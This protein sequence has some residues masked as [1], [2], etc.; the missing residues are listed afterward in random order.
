MKNTILKIFGTSTKTIPD[1]T[2]NQ[3]LNHF[4]DAINIEWEIKDGNYEAVFY[5]NDKEYIAKISKENEITGYKRNLKIEEL[6]ETIKTE[7]EK[8][9][10]IMNAIAIHT[11]SNLLFEI[12]VRD[13]EFKRSL[14]LLSKSGELLQLSAI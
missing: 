7:C 14:L 5:V 12:I 6:P 8:S 13:Q 9:G 3:L 10:E 4:P 2:I 1:K 11:K